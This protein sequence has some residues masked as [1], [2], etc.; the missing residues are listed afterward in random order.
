MAFN[1]LWTDQGQKEW[2]QKD[3]NG[4]SKSL[5]GNVQ[6]TLKK[7]LL[8]MVDSEFWGLKLYTAGGGSDLRKRIQSYKY[9]MKYGILEE[10]MQVMS[11]VVKIL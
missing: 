8:S 5:I 2:Q 10:P 4:C 7:W 1:L 3:C 11:P 9:K 6:K